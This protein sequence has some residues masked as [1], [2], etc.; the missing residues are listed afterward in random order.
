MRIMLITDA[1]K[2]QVNG[3]VR[4][5]AYVVHHCYNMGHELE[6]ITPYD[7]YKT[8]P[9]PTYPDIKLA[10][11]AKK[12]IVKRMEKFQPEAVHI[13]TEGTL[14]HSA[15]S[16]CLKL[17]MPFTTSYH[18][19]FPEYLTARFSF[20][21]L[22]FGYAYMRWFHKPSGNMMV[23]TQAMRDHLQQ[24]GFHNI[25]P[26]TRGVDIEE[27]KPISEKEKCKSPYQGL[28]TPIYLNVGRISVEKNLTEFLDLDLE[29][30]KVIIGDGPALETLKKKYPEV[31]FAGKQFKEAL[32]QYYAHADVFVF[33]SLTDTFG[34]VILEA[35]A[36]GTPVAAFPVAGPIDIIPNS[37]A[38]AVDHDLKKAIEQALSCNHDIVRKHAETY[39]WQACTEEFIKNLSCPPPPVRKRIWRRLARLLGRSPKK[40]QNHNS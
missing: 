5:L 14:G 1:W 18:T 36:C 9:L 39:S 21:P 32:R 7:G 28:K 31:V 2:P 20:I 25:V 16:I 30:T 12:D 38:G 27:F 19:K 33:P 8:L 11:C 29:G 17:N 15:R 24:K 37:G 3:V 10:I 23:A 22:S 26:W 35:M 40:K 6:I 4:T 34:L 13:A